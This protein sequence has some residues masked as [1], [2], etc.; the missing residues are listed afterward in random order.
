MKT[1]NQV[2][3]FK[4]NDDTKPEKAV[5]FDDL[6]E[7]LG[8]FGRYQKFLYILVVLPAIC[9]AFPTMTLVFT[10]G[11]HNHRYLL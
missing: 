6:L 10:L 8:K 2:E 1:S 9:S 7:H 3:D 11:E 5:L 4:I